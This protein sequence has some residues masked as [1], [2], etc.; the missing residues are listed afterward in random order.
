[1]ADSTLSSFELRDFGEKRTIQTRRLW[2]AALHFQFAVT[3]DPQAP[4]T[5][6]DV[7]TTLCRIMKPRNTHSGSTQ[8]RH[9]GRNMNKMRYDAHLGVDVASAT[10]P[11]L[12]LLFDSP[13]L[14]N[15]TGASEINSSSRQQDNKNRISMSVYV[16]SLASHA[17]QSAS[18]LVLLSMI[19]PM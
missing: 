2:V 1:M 12:G 14:E 17:V 9:K 7:G 19:M 11:P 10:L 6:V 15:R 16:H 4:G 13:D 3:E 5:K 18:K 8:M